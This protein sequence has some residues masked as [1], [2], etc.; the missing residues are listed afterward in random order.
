MGSF[1]V[2]ICNNLLVMDVIW[3]TQNKVEIA[4]NQDINSIS[5]ISRSYNHI[6]VQKY[7][8]VNTTINSSNLCTY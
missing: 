1:L 4:K 5:K 2:L 3:R 6:Y 8:I 7:M